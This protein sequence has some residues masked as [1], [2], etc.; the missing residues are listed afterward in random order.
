MPKKSVAEDMEK[1]KQRRD[2]RKKKADEDKIKV[3]DIPDSNGPSKA[4]V[5]FEK[6]IKKQKATVTIQPEQVI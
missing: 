5:Q 3:N 1:L 6:M 2:E 4:D